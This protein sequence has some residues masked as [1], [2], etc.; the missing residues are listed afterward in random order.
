[1]ELQRSAADRLGSQ[2]RH[3]QQTG[4]WCQVAGVG[5]DAGRW[6]EAHV[7]ANVQVR[8]VRP[9]AELSGA[10]GGR[11][12]RDLDQ[13]G[14]QQL[15][16]RG[17][18]RDQPSAASVVQRIDQRGG[19]FVAETVELGAL[20]SS[21]VGEAYDSNALIGG[22]DA[23]L[24]Q[25][26]LFEHPQQPAQVARVDIEPGAQRSGVRAVGLDLPQHTTHPV[27]GHEPGTD[28]ATRQCVA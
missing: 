25:P 17:H 27:V 2:A 11:L 21:G 24:D 14:G 18:R 6:I 5:R 8:E 28:R 9:D 10:R 3:E 22:M 19:Q 15:L 1:M 4:G 7:E 12:D 13:S 16:D 20:G 23:H 26:L